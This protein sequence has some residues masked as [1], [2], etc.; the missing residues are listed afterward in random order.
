MIFVNYK[1]YEESSGDN[2]LSL[3]KIIEEV[4]KESQIKII[5]VV[6]ALDLKEIVSESNLEIW[7]QKV[8]P[9]DFGAH[10]G[11]ILP[12]EVREA[13]AYGTFLNHSENKISDFNVLT[14]TVKVCKEV[15]LK[16][17]V[18]AADLEELKRNLDISP[19]FISYEPPELVGSTDTSVSQ[20][21]P[22]VIKD[23]VALAKDAGIPL[24]IG[25]GVK[26]EEDMRI[27]LQL[28]AAGFAIAS[29]IVKAE[30][31]K[32]ELLQLVEG[33]K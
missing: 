3:T 16:T 9:V 29:S 5:P 24:I 19:D 22:E 18:F 32:K 25:A 2:A 7:A 11:S 6:Q 13:G 10:T 27:G 12:K 20:A 21:K 17:L 1:T 8:D 26:S 28:G 14:N 31:P 30:D 4:S 15:G 33:Y 23:A